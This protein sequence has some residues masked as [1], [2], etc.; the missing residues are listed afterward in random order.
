MF[1]YNKNYN[2]KARIYKKIFSKI[3][4]L[5]IFKAHFEEKLLPLFNGMKDIESI[6]YD[7]DIILIMTSFIKT[8]EY[9]P[10]SALLV[11]SYLP[12]Y[13][14]KNKGVFLDSY[15]LLNQYFVVGSSDIFKIEDNSNTMS[16][17]IT[18]ML[19]THS[20]NDTAV[21]LSTYLLHSLLIVNKII[22]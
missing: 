21:V 16:K 3:F 10:P 15:E 4:I 9:L 12:Q 19:N 22:N 14:K 17:L 7:E 18:I 13:L 11:F 20:E 6:S 1:E 8:L 5:L 2:R